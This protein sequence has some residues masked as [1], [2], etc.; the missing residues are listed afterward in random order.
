MCVCLCFV[1]GSVSVCIC[2]HVPVLVFCTRVWLRSAKEYVTD[3]ESVY[4]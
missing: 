3:A 1:S 2:E 4:L